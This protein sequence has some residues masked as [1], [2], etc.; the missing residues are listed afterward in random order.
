MNRKGSKEHTK[1]EK[2]RKLKLNKQ[3]VKDLKPKDTEAVKGG[4]RG[5]EMNCTVLCP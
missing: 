1:E 5:T 3:T 4:A 2:Q